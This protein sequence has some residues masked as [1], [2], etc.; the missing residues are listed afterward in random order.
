M[1]IIKGITRQVGTFARK[2]YALPQKLFLATNFL[3]FSLRLGL[4]AVALLSVLGCSPEPMRSIVVPE[5]K[6]TAADVFKQVCPELDPTLKNLE[7]FAKGLDQAASEHFNNAGVMGGFD[8]GQ[9]LASY[10]TRDLSELRSNVRV[11]LPDKPCPKPEPKPETKL[12]PE[13]KLPVIELPEPEEKPEPK[14]VKLPTKKPTKKPGKKPVKKPGKEPEKKG[15]GFI[16]SA[17]A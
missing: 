13:P 8:P 17:L 11:A 10:D 1:P 15:G 2:L 5:D 3:R 14:A 16:P 9:P 4:P 7:F 12:A 6:A